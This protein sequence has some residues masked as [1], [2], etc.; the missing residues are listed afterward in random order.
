VKTRLENA[1]ESTQKIGLLDCFNRQYPWIENA[2]KQR[3]MKPKFH[4]AIRRMLPSIIVV[5]SMVPVAHSGQIDPD[6][7]GNILVP[8]NYNGGAPAADTINA[9]GGTT[10]PFRLEIASGAQI[11]GDA[12]LQHGIIV[13]SADYTIINNGIVNASNGRG[14]EA[15]QAFT[16][17]N[18]GLIQGNNTFRGISAVG[19]G[20]II[21]NYSTG[22]IRGSTS[23]GN[24]IT[25][26]ADGG[27][28]TNDGLIEA[29]ISFG[30][31]G[32]N[33]LEIIN[34]FGAIVTGVD[35]GVNAGNNA[36]IKNYGNITSSGANGT[37]LGDDGL[38][39][40][41][42]TFLS[43]TN[44]ADAVVEGQVNGVV[45]GNRAN[46][47]N[48]GRIIGLTGDGVVLSDGD[49]V[50][51]NVYNTPGG[52]FSAEI[53]GSVNGISGG[54]GVVITN[55]YDSVIRGGIGS[56]ISAGS[57]LV[58]ENLELI[59]GNVGITTTAGGATI[60]NIDGIIR[61]IGGNALI[62]GD[63][64]GVGGNLVSLDYG[65]VN[66]SIAASGTGNRIESS[67]SDEISGDISGVQNIDVLSNS[68]LLID[69]NV[70]GP[71]TATVAADGYLYGEGAWQMD[72]NLASDA[73]LFAWDGGYSGVIETDG[74]VVH[75]VNSYLAFAVDP[76]LQITND[77]VNAGLISSVAGTYDATN[78]IISIV[79]GVDLA[80]RNGQY[81]VVE[82]NGGAVLGGGNQIE[83]QFNPNAILGNYFAGTYLD[84]AGNL[85]LDLEHAFAQLPGISGS[86]V[87]LANALDQFMADESLLPDNVSDN[88]NLRNFIENLDRN[89]LD[90]TLQTLAALVAPV[91]GALA[92]SSSVIN[93]NYR[94]HRQVQDHLAS[95]RGNSQTYTTPASRDA[96]GGLIEGQT[97]T[98][99]SR[100]NLWGA[101]SYDHQNLDYNGFDGDGDTGAFTA[102][103]DYR[104]APN[105]LLGILL[106]G[107]KGDLEDGPDIRSLRA[108][109]YGSW[110]ASTGF[111]SDFLLGYGDHDLDF[112]DADGFQGLLTFGYAMGDDSLKH[113]PFMGLEYQSLDVDGF[114][115]PLVNVDG[116]DVESLRGLI[117]YRVNGN[118]GTF[119][120]YASVAYAHEF[121]DGHNRVNA[122]ILGQGFRVNGGEQGSAVLLT[123]GT[124]IAFNQS[125]TLDVGYR[126][127][128]STES[129]GLDSHGGS[130]GLHWSF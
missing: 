29:P 27:V 58:V 124:G 100:G 57:G 7:A 12:G 11:T 54:N 122:R 42:D 71:A 83:Y 86:S 50:N 45:A 4:R 113:G 99:S 105:F 33:N 61:G 76:D 66:G 39:G 84:G 1:G 88:P 102:G 94:I 13:S 5:S 9:S 111:Y 30:I 64:A 21:N 79:P 78:A 103:F 31:G 24:G 59:E 108:A 117:G 3:S 107:S 106:D 6:T 52:N 69:G 130:I 56:G 110:G 75:E 80:L 121:R 17:D 48:E 25:F 43:P 51:S 41:Y 26:S 93:S 89:D 104:V 8:G 14:I 128:I 96:K 72:I 46:I 92:I 74:N 2:K 87:A 34:N 28:V 68:R 91:D 126:G 109:L 125:L 49:G 120:P 95:V 36:D 77:G 118:Y 40:N 63:T 119:R 37:Q 85:V 67:G 10:S 23:G 44:Y 129:S 62:L 82:D 98:T 114:S 35:G 81:V 70:T 90:F 112:T 15:S 60:N 19:A 20:T 116:F 115:T 22:I 101:F 38:L 65:W 123:A 18:Y 127:E 16:L 97:I 55:G 73:M 47:R 53:N 32:L